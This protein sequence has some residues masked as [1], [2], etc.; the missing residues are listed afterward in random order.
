MTTIERSALL[1]CNAEHMYALINDVEA[2]PSFVDGCVGA[3]ILHADQQHIKVQLNIAKGPFNYQII[4]RNL[5]EPP[6]R[7]TMDLVEG[8]FSEWHGVWCVKPLSDAACKVTLTLRFKLKNS[9]LGMAAK[10]LIDPL[11][12]QLLTALVKRSKQL[13]G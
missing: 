11:A 8:P 4:T 3:H 12:N 6:I 2:Y 13:Y 10:T 5:L 1:S 9:L 7:I